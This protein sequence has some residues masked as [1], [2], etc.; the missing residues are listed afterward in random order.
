MYC[1]VQKTFDTHG[2]KEQPV[3]LS[4]EL[5]ILADRQLSENQKTKNLAKHRLK[6][7]SIEMDWAFADTL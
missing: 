4:C 2:R 5:E 1:T 7:M 3:F 6:G